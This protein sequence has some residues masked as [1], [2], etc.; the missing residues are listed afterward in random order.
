MD[1]TELAKRSNILLVL[2]G[3]FSVEW[4][5][6]TAKALR[7]FAELVA[8]EERE[9]CAQLCDKPVLI[10]SEAR[11][12]TNAYNAAMMDCAKAIR[13]RS[14]INDWKKHHENLS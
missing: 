12:V 8:A 3:G 13:D 2:K 5:S 14:K 9:K 10:P 7:E 1:L 6:V 11:V 4:W